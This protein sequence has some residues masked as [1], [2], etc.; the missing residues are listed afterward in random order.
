MTDLLLA[1][2]GAFCSAA[3]LVVMIFYILPT[4]EEL[5]PRKP[6]KGGG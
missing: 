3:N 6:P 4:L 5:D 2:V 1:L